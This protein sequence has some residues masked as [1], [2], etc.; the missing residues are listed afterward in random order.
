M[1]IQMILLTFQNRNIGGLKVIP[2]HP[3]NSSKMAH[4]FKTLFILATGFIL[5][6]GM[7]GCNSKT[8][9][10]MSESLEGENWRMDDTLRGTFQVT[11][12]NHYHNIFLQTR[13]T[14]DFPF[15]NFYVKMIL[16]APD[17]ERFE[18]IKSFEI[19]TKA[20]KWL[21]K[22]LGDLHSYSLPVYPSF[23]PH[24]NGSYSILAVQ[25]MRR[26]D[27]L[28]CHDRGLKVELGEEIF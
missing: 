1:G 26:D 22:G 9:M 15:S 12:T 28:G 3:L 24:K 20:G 25:Y 10:D 16:E 14:G 8:I 17:G 23:V 2:L 21:G 13:L 11:D 5:F 27:L 19:T 6:M 18:S 4:T 7:N